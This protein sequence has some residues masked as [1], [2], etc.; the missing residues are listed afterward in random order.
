MCHNVINCHKIIK[1]TKSDDIPEYFNIDTQFPFSHNLDFFLYF[2]RNKK[3]IQ[4]K[5]KKK[6]KIRIL[7]WFYI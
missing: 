2:F 4:Y 3:Y 6:K 7:G 1:P 5:K